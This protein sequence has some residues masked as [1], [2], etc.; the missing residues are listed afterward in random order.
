MLITSPLTNGPMPVPVRLVNFDAPV[1]FPPPESPITLL[2]VR[3]SCWSVTSV[4]EIVSVPPAKLN[5]RLVASRLS[6]I[7]SRPV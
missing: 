2:P 5:V 4:S 7:G 6:A 1:A 3:I